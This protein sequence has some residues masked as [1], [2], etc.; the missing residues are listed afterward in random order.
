VDHLD[1]G[2]GRRDTVYYDVEMD[3]VTNCE[4]LNPPTSTPSV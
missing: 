4:V 3:T 2:E 1:C